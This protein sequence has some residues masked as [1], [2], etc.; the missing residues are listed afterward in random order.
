MHP[1]LPGAKKDSLHGV[2]ASADAGEGYPPFVW[3]F[4]DGAAQ[5]AVPIA[6]EDGQTGLEISGAPGTVGVAA[7]KVFIPPAGSAFRWQVI[8]R[9]PNLQSSANWELTCLL[10]PAAKTKTRSDD[11]LAAS[12]P[13]ERTL[14]LRIPNGCKLVRLDMR[15]AGG[16]GR[17]PTLFSV[18]KLSLAES[19]PAG[20]VR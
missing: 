12:V 8:D 3:A 18:G 5:G 13:L 2:S 7:A 14:E 17:N 9:T 4:A 11:L 16:I 20:K 1:L 6:L 19:R 10:G 15:V